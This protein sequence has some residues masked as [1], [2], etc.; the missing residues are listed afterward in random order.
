MGKSKFQMRNRYSW[1]RA[2]CR[3]PYIADKLHRQ[4]HF[5]TLA[6]E[7][8][9]L[10]SNR[11]T[12]HNRAESEGQKKNSPDVA[13]FSSPPSSDLSPGGQFNSLPAAHSHLPGMIYPNYLAHKKVLQSQE[14]HNRISAFYRH[15]QSPALMFNSELVMNQFSTLFNPSWLYLAALQDLNKQRTVYFG[16]ENPVIQANRLRL[17][18]E[19]LRGASRLDQVSSEELSSASLSIKRERSP[20]ALSSSDV[21]FSDDDDDNDDSGAVDYESPKKNNRAAS[22]DVQFLETETEKEIFPKGTKMSDKEHP[23]ACK[24]LKKE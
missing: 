24:K 7:L 15:Y 23:P 11:L 2:G 9:C 13:R 6:D 22:Q 16:R 17:A 5:S 19:M 1:L 18:G 4:A 12:R 10:D 20:E 8:H 14:L 3:L 21:A